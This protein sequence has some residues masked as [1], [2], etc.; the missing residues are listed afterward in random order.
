[1]HSPCFPPR[2]LRCFPVHVSNIV[3]AG[4]PWVPNNGG[5]VCPP[6]RAP[7]RS[8]GLRRSCEIWP[9][10]PVPA[11][12]TVTWVTRHHEFARLARLVKLDLVA[13]PKP[14]IPFDFSEDMHISA[15]DTAHDSLLSTNAR[16]TSQLW[17]LHT[18]LR[19]VLS[20]R[21]LPPIDL[22]VGKAPATR[23]SASISRLRQEARF[24][25]QPSSPA[26]ALLAIRS[27]IATPLVDRHRRSERPAFLNP[28]SCV[29][30]QEH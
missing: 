20:F 2:E 19:P 21:S 4:L 18:T 12:G 13:N 1:M 28:V 11:S 25:V 14:Q 3:V 17:H 27:F 10:A 7:P 29:N 6:V 16:C 26:I 15:T 22:P 9:S 24:S 23:R 30:T 5:R 8:P